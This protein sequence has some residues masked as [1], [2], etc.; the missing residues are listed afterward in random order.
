MRGLA[1]LLGAA[2][3]LPAPCATVG[4]TVNRM[5]EPANVLCP[6]FGWKMASDRQGARQTAYRL[7]LGD[8][9][10]GI[11]TS[12]D[13]VGIPY[14]G[15][16]LAGAARYRWTVQVRDE[17]GE[18]ETPAEGRFTTG[19]RSDNWGDSRWIAPVEAMPAVQDGD[20]ARK[21]APPG[22]ACF[23]RTLVNEREVKEAFWSVTA[24][25]VFECAVNGQRIG[26]ALKPG[27]TTP[28]KVRHTF[29]YDVTPQFRT[30]AGATNRLTAMVSAGWGRDHICRAFREAAFRAILTV[31]YRDGGTRR[32]GTDDSWAAAVGGPL[33]KAGIY[34]G[35]DYDARIPFP[36]DMPLARTLGEISGPL[37]PLPCPPVVWRDDLSLAPRVA[38][39]WRTVEGAGPDRFGRVV[40]AR[41]YSG[42][43]EMSL[44]VGETLVVDFGQNAAAVPAFA[45]SAKAGTRLE[46]LP[47][48][49]LNDCSGEKSRGND[50]PAGMVYRRN[51]RRARASGTYVF[52]GTGEETYRPRFTYYGYR[53]L[54]LRADGDVRIRRLR[55]IPLSS[56]PR[57]NETGLFRT[58]LPEVNRL[59]ENVR[60]SLRANYV[61]IPTDCPQRD[62]RL[63]WTADAQVFAPAA[64]RLA[65]VYAFL[66]KWMDD[67]CAT[68]ETN[69]E[70]HAIAPNGGRE[71]RFGWSDAGIA[72]PYTLW[73]RYGDSTV[74]S[75]C[76]ASMMAYMAF[77][78]RMRWD[79]PQYL[80]FQFADWLAFER[81]PAGTW[82]DGRYAGTPTADAVAY[83]RFLGKCHWLQNARQMAIL[84]EGLGK[85]TEAAQFAA[86]AESL[87]KEISVPAC[88]ADLQTPNLFALRLGL[89][90]GED[91]TRTIE[92]LRANF[93][94]HGDCLQTGFLGTGILMDTLTDAAA[95]VDLACTLLLQRKNP[96]WL[97]SVDQGATTVWERW[98][99]YRKDR[100][101]GNAAMNSFNHYA[102]G[103]VVDWMFG[104]LAGI[105]CDPQSPGYRHFGIAPHPDRRVGH[106]EAR[107]DSPHG[108]IV[109]AWRFGADG[110]VRGRFR[111]PANTSATVCLESGRPQNVQ[112]GCYE[113]SEG[114]DELRVLGTVGEE[115]ETDNL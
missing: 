105:R 13:S 80:K 108:M 69:G 51:L 36:S 16:E 81:L 90:R 45:F 29:T 18:W 111:V 19:L 48:E 110:R 24:S 96:S 95:S 34:D 27:F 73:T 42:D 114:S 106:V 46:M 22:T 58:G 61:S 37:R 101:F 107:F 43:E 31:R 38:W 2:S 88:C 9:D 72:V 91:R 102:Y 6:T 98:D 26:D 8:W 99:S 79:D 32:Y 1:V 70:Y 4:L 33:V 103:A 56:I 30:S 86:L 11:V 49:M 64:T 71:P 44:R 85:R 55:S 52:A 84:A 35:E 20:Y 3:V 53:Y 21:A 39:A 83:W 67:L 97:Y 115:F 112:A 23:S 92:R 82:V 93:R 28:S 57:E 5:H 109:S 89:V 113:W 74:P 87:S 54:A 60:W 7:R 12:G 78:S 47:A 25:A 15:K 17:R 66:G 94:R 10:S 65:D 100:G 63:G 104:T 76:W 68:Q 77:L 75:R 41:S 59:V 62:E 50:G 14:G 40:R